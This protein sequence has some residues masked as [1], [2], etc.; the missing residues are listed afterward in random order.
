LAD[1]KVERWLAFDDKERALIAYGLTKC[2]MYD[3]AEIAEEVP[4][5]DLSPEQRARI[6]KM[7]GPVF[8]WLEQINE[9][10][11]NPASFEEARELRIR[12]QEYLDE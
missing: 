9:S 7:M 11:G 5:E 8:E 6:A 10:M 3:V 2:A 4:P 12:M 1:E